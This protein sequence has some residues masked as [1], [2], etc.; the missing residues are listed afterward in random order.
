MSQRSNT[1]NFSPARLPTLEKLLLDADIHPEL[2]PYLRAVGFRTKS[3]RHIR[4]DY[5]KD[6]QLL[7]WA[8][9]YDYILVCHDAHADM[10][11][12]LEF[13]PEMYH[14]GGRVL[15][16]SKDSSQDVLVA[17]GKII[18]H[19]EAWSKWFA[20]NGS[21]QITV[22]QGGINSSSAKER[23]TQLLTKISDEPTAVAQIARR[24]RASR[25]QLPTPVHPDQL[26]LNT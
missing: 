14:K 17:L 20:N 8:R 1:R 21:G 9:R 2:E 22:S 7:R 23:Y 6:A 4:A 3:V 12:R 10:K 11:T 18:L 25:S 13:D 24:S 16:I 5:R 19:R 15:R 26:R